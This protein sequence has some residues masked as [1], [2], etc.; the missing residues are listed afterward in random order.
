MPV[1]LGYHAQYPYDDQS[2]REGDYAD[3]VLGESR[4][5][6]PDQGSLKFLCIDV[7]SW[8]NL[9]QYPREIALITT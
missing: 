5:R 2:I 4:N 3:A 6:C 9:N 8:S 1:L 7:F